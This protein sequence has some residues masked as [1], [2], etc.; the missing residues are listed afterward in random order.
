MFYVKKMILYNT[1]LPVQDT[2]SIEFPE[3]RMFLY[4]FRDVLKNTELKFIQN[5]YF[6]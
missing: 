3:N 5:F 1:F 4:I 2:K 6:L